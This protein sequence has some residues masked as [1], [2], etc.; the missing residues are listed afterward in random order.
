MFLLKTCFCF[1]NVFWMEG[2]V[3][4]SMPLPPALKNLSP[5]SLKWPEIQSSASPGPLN[6]TLILLKIINTGSV[7]KWRS[8][9]FSPCS[10]KYFLCSAVGME[11]KGLE[12]D[13]EMIENCYWI[14]FISEFKAN[15]SRNRSQ[16]IQIEA[17]EKL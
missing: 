7:A 12:L 17:C 15:T 5:F 8:W 9:L 2:D 14:Q 4:Y 6:W 1:K 10:R 13:I 16:N 11:V 3:F